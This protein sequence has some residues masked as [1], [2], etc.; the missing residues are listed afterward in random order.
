M[1]CLLLFGCGQTINSMFSFSSVRT[2]PLTGEP[3]RTAVGVT[4]D[5]N[6]PTQVSVAGEGPDGAVNLQYQQTPK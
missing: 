4:V 2:N 3:E 6:R 5:K 1:G